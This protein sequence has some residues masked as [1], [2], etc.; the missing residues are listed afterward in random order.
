MN[1]VVFVV[2]EIVL[3]WFAL[4]D[5]PPAMVYSTWSKGAAVGSPSYASISLVF[6]P[7]AVNMMTIEFPGL[8]PGRSTI[9]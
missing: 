9:S 3:V 8:Q 6:D 4:Q 5:I 2:P 7:E 1:V